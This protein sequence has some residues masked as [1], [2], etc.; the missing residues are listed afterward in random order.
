MRRPVLPHH[1]T[2]FAYPAV[3]FNRLTE[4]IFVT[5]LQV[6]VIQATR[7]RFLPRFLQIR[8]R[9][10]HPCL[11]GRFRSLRPVED[12]HLLN[13]RHAWQSGSRAGCPAR[14]ATP[15]DVPFGIRRFVKRTPVG[16]IPPAG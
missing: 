6:P 7:L 12:F 2:Y 10:P 9:A 3:S 5:G 16:G 15:P 14:L 4:R 13:T 8:P 1:R 11:D